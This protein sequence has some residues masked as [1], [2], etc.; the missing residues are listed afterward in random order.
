[1]A[2]LHKQ[3][4]LVRGKV[5]GMKNKVK[6]TEYRVRNW[7]EYNAPL[8]QRGCL[9]IWVEEGIARQWEND[10]KSGKRG[11]SKKYTDLASGLSRVEN[12][13][14]VCPRVATT[15]LSSSFAIA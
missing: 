7:R 5:L 6:K 2:L 4:I 9:T 10:Q 11:A 8:V 3:K 14:V 1:M 12:S 15:P 13:A